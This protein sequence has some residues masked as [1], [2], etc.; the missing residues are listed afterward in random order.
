MRQSLVAGTGLGMVLMVCGLIEPAVVAGQVVG[1]G[2]TVPL[3]PDGDPDLQGVW[4]NNNATPLERPEEWAGKASLTDEELA[5]LQLAALEAVGD[6]DALFGDQLVLAAIDGIEATSYDPAT[7]NYNQ[8][9]VRFF[10]T[11]NSTIY[12]V[13]FNSSLSASLI[14]FRFIYDRKNCN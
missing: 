2:W 11:S 4:A 10:N 3:T 5:S 6:G 8:F 14:F 13:F 9:W 7:G 1:T 12:E